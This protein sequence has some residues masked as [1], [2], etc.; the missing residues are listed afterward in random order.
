MYAWP[1]ENRMKRLSLL[2]F[3]L[4]VCLPISA[5]QMSIGDF[6]RLK[7]LKVQRE[8]TV[9][10]LDL[11]TEESGFSF[12][13]NGTLAVE[14]Q[15]GEGFLQLQLPHRTTYLTVQHPTYGRL[16]W[17]VPKGKKLKRFRHYKAV[18]YAG[19]PTREYKSPKQ[20]AVFHLDPP[21]VVLQLDSATAPVRQA[22]AEYYLPLGEH[23]YRVEAP[24]FSPQEGSFTLSDSVRTEL[25]INLQPF[26]SYLSV[27][28]EWTGGNL[29]IDGRS[30][31][32]ENATSYRLPEGSHRVTYF[33]EDQCYYDTLIVMGPAQ[34]QV[35]EVKMKDMSPRAVKRTDPSL[36]TPPAEPEKVFGSRVRLTA[37]DSTADIW[38]DRERMAFREWEGELS[39]GFHLAQAVVEGKESIPVRIWVQEGISQDLVLPAPGSGSGLLNIHSNVDGASILVDG[40]YYGLTPQIVRVDADKG[41]QVMLVKAGYKS[42]A[43]RVQPRGNHQVDVYVKLKKKKI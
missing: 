31:P 18:L 43:R 35:L 32:Q 2:L 40:N 33:W 39:A 21:D 27:N 23:Q 10:L 29:Y 9:A 17:V 15:P 13:A 4:L 28:V 36:L 1:K 22:V 26:Y 14:A 41:C 5:Q 19:D 30:L 38:I 8:K 42:V 16:I 37:A 3:L 34:K 20:W 11:E 7:G 24:F 12:L 25:W 6:V